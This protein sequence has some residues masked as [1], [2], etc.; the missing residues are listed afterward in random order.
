MHTSLDATRFQQAVTGMAPLDTLEI[1]NFREAPVDAPWAI[2]EQ[3]ILTACIQKRK[4]NA[5]L[6]LNGM[7]TREELS[8]EALT[9]RSMECIDSYWVQMPAGIL[10]E[11]QMVFHEACKAWC[12]GVGGSIYTLAEDGCI[13]RNSVAIGSD[14]AADRIE[15]LMDDTLLLSAEGRGIYPFG[16]DKIIDINSDE[17]WNV[18][19][20][21]IVIR[22]GK[23]FC[24]AKEKLLLNAA[25][26]EFDSW[27]AMS[28]GIVLGNRGVYTLHAVW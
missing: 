14:A 16:G 3:G 23:R 8:G 22:I 20:N 5:T 17:E 24:D 15:V 10:R 28:R 9:W 6:Y 12:V 7:Q 11:R 25:D 18:A 27:D 2:S 21:N 1:C 26:I 4:N 13:K 19:G